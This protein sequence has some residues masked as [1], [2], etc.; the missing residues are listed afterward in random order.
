[1]SPKGLG[2]ASAALGAA[3]SPV[4]RRS[5]TGADGSGTSRRV[6]RWAA[7]E[8]LE[9]DRA[10]ASQN[11]DRVKTITAKLSKLQQGLEVDK[12]KAR[13]AFEG[14]VK[15]LEGR[16]A[17]LS[18]EQ[19]ARLEEADAQIEHLMEALGQERLAR[20]LLDERKTKEAELLQ[21][22][23]SAQLEEFKASEG[24]T[25]RELATEVDA[26]RARL[27]ESALA[28]Q[29]AAIEMQRDGI[30]ALRRELEAERESRQTG[31]QRLA[32]MLTTQ[33][34]SQLAELGAETTALRTGNAALKERADALARSLETEKRARADLEE[35]I[36][37]TLDDLLQKVRN[38]IVAERQDREAMEETLLKL[39]EETCSRVEGGLVSPS[40]SVR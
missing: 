4:A 38:E 28:A 15:E 32:D 2:K 29:K 13:S 11:K 19:D 20:E 22:S 7:L 10:R 12:S 26:L 34:K 37:T 16:I 33:V 30:Q 23:V 17:T 18:G 14:R 35:H 21:R 39:I 40:S 1:M 5:P 8:E 6:P 24:K 25:S 27:E 9:R 3:H 31:E 36:M